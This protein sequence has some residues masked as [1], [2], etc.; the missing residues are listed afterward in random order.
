MA[1]VLAAFA[2]SPCRG[3]DDDLA[4]TVKV[5]LAIEAAKPSLV[6]TV[7]KGIKPAK[8]S[9][10]CGRCR[11]D[12]DAVR[13]EARATGKPVLVFVGGCECRGK[14]L[15]DAGAFMVRVKKYEPDGMDDT[16]RIVVLNRKGESAELQWSTLP[17]E[18]KTPVVR[19]AIKDAAAAGATATKGETVQ[20]A[21]VQAPPVI[22]RIVNGRVVRSD[23][24]DGRCPAK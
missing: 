20:P 4:R 11:T 8:P 19:K 13:D 23:C 18:A 10:D 16:P 7:P 3:D 12:L 6:S 2:L 22:Y 24:P 15:A 14:E 1:A 17:A 9:D 21:A 5:A